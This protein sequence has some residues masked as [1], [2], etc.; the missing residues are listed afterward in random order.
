MTTIYR[1][2]DVTVVRDDSKWE[3][4]KVKPTSGRAKT[5]SGES[6]WSDAERYACDIDRNAIGC[7]TL[8]KG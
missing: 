8:F 5:F 4:Y 2:N 6:A 7:V 3:V 1:S